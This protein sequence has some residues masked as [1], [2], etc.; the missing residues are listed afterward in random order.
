MLNLSR[1]CWPKLR[2]GGY[3]LHSHRAGPCGPT[4]APS[5]PHRAGL[6]KR[7]K[8][9][10]LPR[11]SL[12]P[13]TI[14]PCCLPGALNGLEFC[15]LNMDSRPALCRPSPLQRARP[16]AKEGR[17]ETVCP[18]L[19]LAQG[20]QAPQD[21]SLA[22]IW[23]LQALNKQGK[24]SLGEALLAFGLSRVVS[25]FAH[26]QGG[27]DALVT[28]SSPCRGSASKNVQRPTRRGYNCSP[29]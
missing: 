14:V 4:P 29:T 24:V 11:C 12:L 25:E 28:H 23:Y 26:W 6:R 1:K 17:K 19:P 15:K 16:R 18:R 13:H 20:H 22:C 7:E 8:A 3:L 21:P 27:T 10:G 2:P 5:L 9:S